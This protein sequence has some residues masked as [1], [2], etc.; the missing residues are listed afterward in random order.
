MKNGMFKEFRDFAMKGN[1]IDL[2]VGVVIGMAF[3]A[4]V[5]SLVDDV[6]MPPLG[7]LMGNVDFSSLYITI[8]EGAMSGPYNTLAE[9]TQA[10]AVLIKYGMFINTI[11]SFII[12]SFS[13]FLLIKQLNRFNKEEVAKATPPAPT[14][15]VLLL[16]EIRDLL[17]LQQRIRI[18]T[19]MD[20]KE[21]NSKYDESAYNL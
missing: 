3:G 7:V 20:H 15:D 12:I 8:K 16:G 10:G 9:A 18:E 2:A 4:V 1:V 11:V 5:K 17:K 19:L 13:V 6:I 21:I 14:E